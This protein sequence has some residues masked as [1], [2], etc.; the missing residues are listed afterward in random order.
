MKHILHRAKHTIHNSLTEEV[1]KVAN[2]IALLAIVYFLTQNIF[3]ALI[4]SAISAVVLIGWN[5][6]IF[7]IL[8]LLFIVFCPFLL[9]FD[10]KYIAEK[11]AVYAYYM[12]ALGVILQVVAYIREGVQGGR[13]HK[14]Q[15]AQTQTHESILKRKFFLW[16]SMI[17]TTTLVISG[18]FFYLFYS[19]LQSELTENK[20]EFMKLVQKNEE[21]VKEIISVKPTPSESPKVMEVPAD[22]VGTWESVKIFVIN[23][24]E[25]QSL[26]HVVAEQFK[27][28]GCLNVFTSTVTS[29][30][31][32]VTTIQYCSECYNV[33]QE[34]SSGLLVNKNLMLKEDPKLQNQITV[35]LG[36]DQ[37][38]V[39]N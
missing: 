17:V 19:K 29:T 4:L 27:K 6:K 37:I 31:I 30:P 36:K 11:M 28:L 12:L 3:L 9:A 13:E 35:Q 21:Q 14:K 32:D 34:L 23:T 1:I 10:K 18:V 25:Q 22:Q 7:F 2:I 38:P 15:Q 16:T 5:G 26:E 24:T 39:K 33:A 8:G 20:N